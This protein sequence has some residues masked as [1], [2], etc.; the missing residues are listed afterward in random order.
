MKKNILLTTGADK[1]QKPL[2]DV[3]L[4]VMERYCYLYD[5]DID[6]FVGNPSEWTSS[7]WARFPFMKE[8]LSQY[9][10]IVWLD[11]DCLIM[12]FNF[13]LEDFAD[14]DYFYILGKSLRDPFPYCNTGVSWIKNC[15]QSIDF[16]DH[17][18]DLSKLN[19]Y[20]DDNEAV[21]DIFIQENKIQDQK[22]LKDVKFLERN[23]TNAVDPK[24][25]PPNTVGTFKK[26]DF[27]YHRAGGGTKLADMQK[28][29]KEIN[30]EGF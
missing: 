19:K 30:Y 22:F 21:N 27:I 8:R 29:A 12:N 16:I 11:A 1:K 15:Q 14:E 13:M 2:L 24:C 7:N 20:G 18:I 5:Y 3:S 17:I 28:Y 10:W 4:P 9:D 26:G 23:P 6:Y 25:L